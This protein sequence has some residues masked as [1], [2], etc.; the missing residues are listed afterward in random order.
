MGGK[1]LVPTQEFVT[2]LV[3]A[4][5]ASDICGI[6]SLLIARTDANS[7]KLL[8]SDSDIRDLE[9]LTGERTNDGFLGFRGALDPSIG[10]G[11]SYAPYSDRIWWETSAPA[12]DQAGR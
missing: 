3:A 9:F 1:V 4:R 2:K 5:L 11:R 6:P 10:P 8:T 12:I 7:A